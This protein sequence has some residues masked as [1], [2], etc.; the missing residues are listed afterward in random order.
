MKYDYQISSH[1]K[2]RYL[3]RVYIVLSIVI[4]VA[5]AV[6]AFI[7]IDS[8]LQK[9]Q[10]TPNNTTTEKSTAYFAPATKIFRTQYFQ[11]QS[12][13]SWVEMPAESNLST[14]VYR[15]FRNNLIEQEL[16]IYV[17]DIPA[18]LNATR[19]LPVSI[20]Q[21]RQLSINQVSEHCNKAVGGPVIGQAQVSFEQ[22]TMAC[23]VDGTQY[24]VLVGL[25]GGTTNLTLSRPDGSNEVYAIYYK[26]VKASPDSVQFSQ[27]VSSFQTR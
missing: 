20:K 13:D 23:D 27:I 17:G 4:V 19:V 21:D 6:A 16:I 22:V 26:N 8:Y 10:N 24:Q 2:K 15:S 7:K 3:K 12:D 9:S 1:S 14:Y 25:I 11:F 18:N 5:L